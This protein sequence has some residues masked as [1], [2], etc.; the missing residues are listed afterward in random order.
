MIWARSCCTCVGDRNDDFIEL[1]PSG[2][3]EL[4]FKFAEF[5]GPYGDGT[6]CLIQIQNLLK[7]FA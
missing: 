2:P 7:T 6:F 3:E 4:P 1:A 5:G